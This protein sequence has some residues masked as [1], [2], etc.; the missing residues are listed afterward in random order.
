MEETRTFAVTLSSTGVL[1]S[2]AAET[3]GTAVPSPQPTGE[4]PALTPSWGLTAVFVLLAAAAAAAVT[5]LA[6]R[7]KRKSTEHT[8]AGLSLQV[9]KLHAQGAREGQ[10]DCFS[11]SPEDLCQ[12]HGLLAVVA[13]G[14]GGLEDG[15]QVSQTAVSAVMNA[16]F[17]LP[18]E[19]APQQL[20]LTLLQHA[21]SA[22]NYLLGV[23][24]IGQAGSTLVAGLLKDGRFHF[25]SVGDSRVCLF[26]NG[27]LTQLNREH[28]YRHELE[29]R[30]V[31]GEGTL[32]EAGTHPRAAG[33]TS[34]L[35]MGQLRL[36]DQPD[37]P[38]TAQPG[39]RFLLM[40]DGVYNALSEQEL[41]LALALD[42]Q[43]AADA[44][45]R[46]V[47][48]RGWPGQDNYTAVIVQ[49]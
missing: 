24:R 23:E 28:I 33:L 26:R 34:Y 20:L 7:R 31:N 27:Q 48:A 38:V 21:N 10:Q 3:A 35:G 5:A 22:V 16:F 4:G 37:Q 42:A 32:E 46:A 30:A 11:V 44:I 36:V 43:E 13:D 25:L 19:T 18:T 14:M 49:C 47:E 17:S 6:L 9:G 45:G 29:L 8:A 12:S 39:D 2:P 15:D 1:P 40:S 41:C